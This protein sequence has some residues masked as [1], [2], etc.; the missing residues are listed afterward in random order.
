MGGNHP[1]W[2]AVGWSA[3]A[4]PSGESEPRCKHSAS[5]PCRR[6]RDTPGAADIAGAIPLAG[7]RVVVETVGMQRYAGRRVRPRGRP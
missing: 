4:Q 5:T 6:P 3:A 2:G 7:T 1:P